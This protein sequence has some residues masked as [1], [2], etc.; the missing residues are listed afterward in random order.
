M[1]NDLKEQIALNATQKAQQQLSKSVGAAQAT[2]AE[3]DEDE[4]QYLFQKA[5]MPLL[6]ELN[7]STEEILLQD[8][9]GRTFKITMCED[10]EDQDEE[11][12]DQ[13]ILERTN[14]EDTDATHWSD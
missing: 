12:G 8:N 9:L 5:V 6:E 1:K 2:T 13:V 4:K 3:D 14:E 10:E 7:D 11:D